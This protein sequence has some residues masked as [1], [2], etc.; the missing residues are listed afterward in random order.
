MDF[1]RC[2]KRVVTGL[3]FSLASVTAMADVVAIVSSESLVS[4]LSKHEIADIYLGRT[5]RFPNGSKVE[6]ID[7]PEGSNVRDEF[8]Q[9]F[10][11]KTPAQ[12]KAH[13]SRL[14]FTGRGRPP[15]QATSCG[16][17]KQ[18]LAD[19]PNAIGYVDA[20]CVDDSVAVL[21]GG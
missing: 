15:K 10:L 8:Y 1:I 6:P 19:N 3:A 12:I 11:D 18:I 13:W 2:L 20:S 9:R 5:S 16:D 7:L 21:V 14:I 17:V 4:S